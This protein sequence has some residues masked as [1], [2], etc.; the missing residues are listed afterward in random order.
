MRESSGVASS[1]SGIGSQL[2]SSYNSQGDKFSNF[3]F[4][5]GET[6]Y[7]VRATSLG[8]LVYANFYKTSTL[9]VCYRNDS[10]FYGGIMP[11]YK[12]SALRNSLADVALLVP[13][14]FPNVTS[15]DPL[16]LPRPPR[17]VRMSRTFTPMKR[18]VADNLRALFTDSESTNTLLVLRTVSTPLETSRRVG[19]FGITE[20]GLDVLGPY[21][22][23]TRK[24]LL[25]G[26]LLP[27][28]TVRV[29]FEEWVQRFPGKPEKLHHLVCEYLVDAIIALKRQGSG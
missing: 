20:Y 17:S 29:S 23:I 11:G 24:H 10:D 8:L 7:Y 12:E 22:R 6:R 15:V 25:F 21:K 28:K 14:F 16:E 2:G 3:Y 18:L 26:K 4:R 13:Q 5:A 1:H 19:R 27:P 9:K